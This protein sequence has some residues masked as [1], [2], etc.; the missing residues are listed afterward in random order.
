[1]IWV[2]VLL[3]F[4]LLAFLGAATLFL[5]SY[6]YTEPTPGLLWRAPAAAAVLT[7]L[8]AL[9]THLAYRNPGRYD[10]LFAFSP[11][12]DRPRPKR[13]WAVHDSQR[14]LY[15]LRTGPT[16]LAEY[17]NPE[18]GKHWSRSPAVIVEE[19]GQEVRFEA[20]RDENGY[21][22]VE[23]TR[24]P[25]GLGWLVG[26]GTEQA[27]KYRDSRGRVMTEDAIGQVSTTRTGLLLGNL[28]L[29]FFHLALWFACLWLLLR[30]QWSHAL[31]LAVVF[32]LIMTIP[33]LPMLLGQASTAGSQ[34]RAAT[35]TDGRAEAPALARPL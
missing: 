16:G 33:I 29:N 2:L 20:D 18:S 23:R 1:M 17:R 31:G 4:A 21:Y 9:W 13:L 34:P 30:F 5:Q 6:F 27:L 28:F 8:F 24:P 11:Q 22:K 15:E 25:W 26:P 10:S 14:T 19:D 35:A 3:F 12:E 32:W 7:A